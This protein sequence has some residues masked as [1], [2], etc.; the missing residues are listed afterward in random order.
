MGP[1]DLYSQTSSNYLSPPA[2]FEQQSVTHTFPGG[3]EYTR[4][5]FTPLNFIFITVKWLVII[6]ATSPDGCED[7]MRKEG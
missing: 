7:L 6:P 3:A 1:Q 4:K 2:A 5:L